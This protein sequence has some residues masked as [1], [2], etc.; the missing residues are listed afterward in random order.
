M[1]SHANQVQ[2]GNAGFVPVKEKKKKKGGGVWRVV[3]WISLIAFLGAVSAL[4]YIAWGYFS[5]DQGYKQV[6]SSAF[7]VADSTA[8]DVVEEQGLSVADLEVDWEYLRSVNPAIV[9]WVYMPGTRINYPVVQGKDN[10]EYLWVDFNLKS[11][12]NG[13]IFLDAANNPAFTD[14]NN[15]LYGH[16]MNDG[17]MFACIS[18]DLVSNEEFN[19]HRT[20][21]VLTPQL[22]YRCTTFAVVVTDGWDLLVQTTFKNAEERTSYVQDKMD[23][24]VVQPSEGMPKPEDIKQIF[25][26]S[27]CD[28]TRDNGRAVLFAQVSDTTVPK[29]APA[30]SAEPIEVSSEDLEALEEGVAVADQ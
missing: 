2:P 7:V 17:S 24:S 25:T 19:K 29:S 20:L 23:R 10:D 3:F 4:G 11:S 21:Y 14:M 16:H 8:E 30:S 5:S 15:V 26:L 27:T 13:S 12:R 9:A 18:N 1:A 28:Y 6:A 22:N